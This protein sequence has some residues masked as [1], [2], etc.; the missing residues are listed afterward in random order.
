MINGGPNPEAGRKLVDYLL[1][2]ETE[3][4]LA[5]ADCAQIPLHSGIETPPDIPRIENLR[6]MKIS[7]AEVAERMQEIQPLLKDWAGY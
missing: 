2:P 1:S 6:V 5:L 3:R 4:K 7:Y